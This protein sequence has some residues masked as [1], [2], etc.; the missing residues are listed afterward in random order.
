MEH[1]SLG[2]ACP[3]FWAVSMHPR[4]VC[5]KCLVQ[6]Y[7]TAVRSVEEEESWKAGKWI[8]A[9]EAVKQREDECRRLGRRERIRK[10]LEEVRLNLEAKE[11]EV[12]RL[13]EAIKQE[14]DKK[15]R[16]DQEMKKI[17]P[18]ETPKTEPFQESPNAEKLA[19]ERRKRIQ[20]VLSV[21]PLKPCDHQ[22]HK[23]ITICGGL[24]VPVSVTVDT[25]PAFSECNISAALGMLVFI[26]RLISEILDVP[27]PFAMTEA[28]SF[29]TIS[30]RSP[31]TSI[32]PSWW[33]SIVEVVTHLT[34]APSNSAYDFEPEVCNITTFP[35]WVADHGNVKHKQGFVQG[36]SALNFNIIT[37]LHAFKVKVKPHRPPT[38]LLRGGPTAFTLADCLSKLLYDTATCNVVPLGYPVW[39]CFTGNKA[40]TTIPSGHYQGTLELES[41]NIHVRAYLQFTDEG[42]VNG[43]FHIGSAEAFRHGTLQSQVL[44]GAHTGASFGFGSNNSG[45]QTGITLLGKGVG[46]G[47]APELVGKW[48]L[49]QTSQKQEDFRLRMLPRTYVELAPQYV[50]DGEKV[51][52]SPM[53]STQPFPSPPE[54]PNLSK[55]KV[56]NQGALSTPCTSY[57]GKANTGKGSGMPRVASDGSEGWEI[58][59]V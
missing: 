49:P 17:T 5:K 10:K 34:V 27:L 40:A 18:C 9:S 12:R 26:V 1:C 29:S 19:D 28:G 43:K 58:V 50:L 15:V 38:E 57:F 7:N 55:S 31:G 8:E 39:R 52:I 2:I 48:Q 25:L 45:G 41:G 14:R 47:S 54:S 20:E 56:L 22:N 4:L 44:S 13:Q 46:V 11:E 16:L 32:K 6:D 24:C 51:V 53:Q 35:L 3:P 37:I 36:L 23:G 21:F 30:L 42:T 59:D 33:S